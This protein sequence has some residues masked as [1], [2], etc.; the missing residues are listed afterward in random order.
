MKKTTANQKAKDGQMNKSAP[1][2]TQHG[3][4]RR[5][6]KPQAR[7][8]DTQLVAPTS[9]IGWCNSQVGLLDDHLGTGKIKKGD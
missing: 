9:M 3:A 6:N 1:S 7:H 8:N 4:K 2:A 5:A